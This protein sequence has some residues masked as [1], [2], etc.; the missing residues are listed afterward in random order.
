[1]VSVFSVKFTTQNRTSNFPDLPK[2]IELLNTIRPNTVYVVST[3]TVLKRRGE[4]T[5]T[6]IK[7]DL[8]LPGLV[9]MAVESAIH[10]HFLGPCPYPY[11]SIKVPHI[12][13]LL[14]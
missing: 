13:E 4:G 12:F 8:C 3:A 9:I 6:P 5:L 7:P 1:M 2:K 11:T 14:A 10:L